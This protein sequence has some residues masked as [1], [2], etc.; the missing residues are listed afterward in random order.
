VPRTVILAAFGA[1]A[2][3]PLTHAPYLLQTMTN[4]WLYAILAVS[5]TLVAGTSGQISLGHAGLLAIG[6]YASALLSLDQG[7]PVPLA[8]LLAGVIAAALGTLLVY[9]SF[10]LRGHYVSVATLAVGEIVSLVIL[11]WTS[12]THGPI[13]VPGIP[14]LTFFGLPLY[15][16]E[17]TYWIALGALAILALLQTRLLGSHLG[18]TWRA[19]RDDD[20]AARAYGVSLSRYKGLAFGFGGFLAGIS[21]AITAHVFSYINHE[22]F[23]APISL[24]ALTIVILGGLGNVA[25][26]IIGS[27]LLIGLPELFRAAAEY[28]MLIYGLVLLLL[29]RFR[30]QGILGTV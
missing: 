26:A 8:I 2:L 20:V 27:V 15:S 18:R 25:G 23:N 4:A 29:I 6:G 24:L 17:A 5:L 3:L 22:T 30:P 12:L 14:P 13:G 9:P 19:V 16:A 1:A 11:N 7:M 21:G 10:R 28:R